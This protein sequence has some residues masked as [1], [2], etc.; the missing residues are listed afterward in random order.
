VESWSQRV[1]E[2]FWWKERL[3]DQGVTSMVEEM[4]VSREIFV[5]CLWENLR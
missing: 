1:S 3:A 4:E 5:W 2:C